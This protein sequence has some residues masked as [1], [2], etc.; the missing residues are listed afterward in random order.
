MTREEPELLTDIPAF[1][2]HSTRF[3][4]RKS[5]EWLESSMQSHLGMRFTIW[6]LDL[7]IPE[8]YYLLSETVILV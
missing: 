4:R 8:L 7:A 3:L 2:L 5:P 1:T 6:S